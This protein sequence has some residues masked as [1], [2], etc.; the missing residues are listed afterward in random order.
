M[1]IGDAGI[2]L[3]LLDIRLANKNKTK[4]EYGQISTAIKQNDSYVNKNLKFHLIFLIQFF[5][6]A[7]N[8]F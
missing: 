7:I 5:L 8:I 4:R 2:M 1:T 6:T 3:V